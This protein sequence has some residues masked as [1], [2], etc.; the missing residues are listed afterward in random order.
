MKDGRV[1]HGLRGHPLYGRWLGMIQRCTD[2]NHNHYHAYGARGISVCERWRH[3]PNFLEDMGMPAV[4]MSIDRIDANKG[5]EP[6]NC[7]WATSKEQARNTTR[8]RLISFNGKTQCLTDWAS[9]LGM[10][11]NA[12]ADRLKRLPVEQ[13]M[14]T[15]KLTH[16]GI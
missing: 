8:T 16:K 4:G 12:L 5:Y 7:V 1:K 13:A 6:D 10:G 14:T 3:F 2:P 15:P 9:E 11:R